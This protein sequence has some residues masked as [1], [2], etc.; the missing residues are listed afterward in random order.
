MD[1][2]LGVPKASRRHKA[3][4]TIMG[5]SLNANNV[6]ESESGGENQWLFFYNSL[7]VKYV[8]KVANCWIIMA[9]FT[10]PN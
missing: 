5:M 4:Y 1:A 8:D 7:S 10:M 6:W 2:I 9:T 3:W